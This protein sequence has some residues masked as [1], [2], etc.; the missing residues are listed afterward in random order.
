MEE[1]RIGRRE[2][3]KEAHGTWREEKSKKKKKSELGVSHR[4]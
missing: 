3:V 4:I 1:L 2:K